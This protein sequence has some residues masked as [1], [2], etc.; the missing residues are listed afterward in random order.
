MLRFA[1]TAVILAAALATVHPDS[2]EPRAG[3]MDG[4]AQATASEQP[5]AAALGLSQAAPAGSGAK[6]ERSNEFIPVGIGWG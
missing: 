2:T 4:R 1:L 5:T 3:A 6:V